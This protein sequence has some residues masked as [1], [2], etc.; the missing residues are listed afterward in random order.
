M[1]GIQ[2]GGLPRVR[3]RPRAA[4]RCPLTHRADAAPARGASDDTLN[5][6]VTL[7]NVTRLNIPAA[8]LRV[9]AD[10]RAGLAVAPAEAAA[11]PTTAKRRRTRA[12]RGSGA[13]VAAPAQAQALSSC[14]DSFPLAAA[15]SHSVRLSLVP[16][17]QVCVRGCARQGARPRPHAPS[18]RLQL[19]AV[20]VCELRVASPATGAALTKRQRVVVTD[21]D[22]VRGHPAASS[23]CHHAR[24]RRPDRIRPCARRCMCRRRRRR[25]PARCH[26]RLHRAASQGAAAG[27]R[28]RLRAGHVLRRAR[29]RSRLGAG[30]T[31]RV[32]LVLAPAAGRPRRWRQGRRRG[33]AD[34]RVRRLAPSGCARGRARVP[35]RSGRRGGVR[36]AAGA[37]VRSGRCNVRRGRVAQARAVPPHV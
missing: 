28:A 21:W 15:S 10:A 13:G 11:E 4:A 24:A 16:R 23:P 9:E 2:I 29:R 35:A 8:D 1:D 34:D 12:P 20:L 26:G 19:P 31:P 5:L 18:S 22:V 25:G 7:R 36:G 14:S 33:A 3:V 32:C 37:G 30:P 27:A 6:L 17:G